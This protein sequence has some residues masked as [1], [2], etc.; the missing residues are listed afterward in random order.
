[1]LYL[2]VAVAGAL[3]VDICPTPGTR[4]PKDFSDVISPGKI[5]QITDSEIN[6]GGPVANTGIAMKTF[7]LIPSLCGRIGRDEFGKLLYDKLHRT[8]LPPAIETLKISE[9][10]STAYSVILTPD[11][12]DRA[13]L[14]YPGAND[15]FVPEDID[16]N[17]IKRCKL[18]HFGHPSTMKKMYENDGANLA[19]VMKT[20]K[21]HGIVTS[22]D[23]CA[24]DP[25]SDAAAADWNRVLDNVLP[26]VD[27]FLPSIG[28]L[29][30]IL[31]PFGTIDEIE[32]AGTQ[33][34]TGASEAG[35]SEFGVSDSS[36]SLI[37]LARESAEKIAEKHETCILIKLGEY[38]MYYHN[39]GEEFFERIEKELSFHHRPLATWEGRQGHRPAIPAE[40]VVSGLGAG[41]TSI[42]AYLACLLHSYDFDTTLRLALTEG[43]LCVSET[44]ATGGL[45]PLD[46]LL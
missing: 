31:F 42:A 25:A 23:L 13:I 41:D 44:S 32:R 4:N 29:E 33:N 8:V 26:Y 45:V 16:W 24:I 17:H 14:Q 15:N 11:G 27:F 18:F 9:E 36:K 19:E 22:L 37:D 7:G 6:L 21:S 35:A 43:A 28:D 38:G 10:D 20:A 3:G 12:L 1:M 46:E 5:T 30:G 34:E 40:K 39:P 2:R